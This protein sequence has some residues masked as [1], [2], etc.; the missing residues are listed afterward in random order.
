MSASP[1]DK[2]TEIGQIPDDWGVAALGDG[3]FVGIARAG[4]TPLRG[5]KEYYENGDILFVKIEDMTKGQKYLRDTATKITRL[6]LNNSSTWLVPPKSVLFSMYASFG[7]AAINEVPMA[8]NQAIIALVPR[9][10]DDCDFLYYVVKHLKAALHRHLRETTQKNLNAEIVKRLR[11]PLPSARERRR[12]GTVLSTVDDAIE[13]TGEIIAKTQQLKKGLMQQLLTRGIG[14]T[15]FK[16]TETG[17]VPEEWE[18]LRLDDIL[19]DVRYG[20]SVRANIEGRGFPVLG[21]PNILTGEIDES[22]LRHVELPESQR[23]TLALGDGDILVVRTNANPEYVGRSALFAKRN[24]LWLFA[25]YLIRLRF[26]T[27]RVVPSYLA[28][29]LQT[30]GVRKRFLQIARTSAGNYNINTQGI[31]SITVSLPPIEEQKQIVSGL[32]FVDNR[33]RNERQRK[34]ELGDLKKGLMQALLTGKVRVTVD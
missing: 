9:D 1:S 25:S 17:E 33:M 6:G 2:L 16:Q 34:K 20:T 12:I 29:L 14:H 5:I 4:G 3:G 27:A 30:E 22:N 32:S 15:K 21:I 10:S 11:I 7:E 24:G 31:R 8:T 23:K 28:K 13:K 18:V 26:E 19:L